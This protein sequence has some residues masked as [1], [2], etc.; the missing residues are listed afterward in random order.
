[1]SSNVIKI[2]TLHFQLVHFIF[3][4]FYKSTKKATLGRGVGGFGAEMVI[5]KNE[6]HKMYQ[7]KI[8]CYYFKHKSFDI[9]WQ[10][11]EYFE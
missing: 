3:I 5:Y 11:F 4:H 9:P 7:L 10:N 6:K 8:R 2:K 1:M